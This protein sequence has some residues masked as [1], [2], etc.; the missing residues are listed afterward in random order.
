M[1]PSQIVDGENVSDSFRC[2]HSIFR[3]ARKTMHEQQRIG[4]CI[5]VGIAAALKIEW[6]NRSNGNRF[7]FRHEYTNLLQCGATFTHETNTSMPTDV[8]AHA[9]RIVSAC[10]CQL[11]HWRARCIAASV[12]KIW[13]LLFFS[14]VSRHLSLIFAGFESLCTFTLFWLASLALN[15]L[16]LRFAADW[17]FCFASWNPIFERKKKQCRLFPINSLS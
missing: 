17:H 1:L 4:P 2:R 11:R 12:V 13:I 7:V 8:W 10:T 15:I 3:I 14:F 16:Q 9:L 6:T 5:S